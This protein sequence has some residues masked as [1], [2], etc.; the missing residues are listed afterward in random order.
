M[1]ESNSISLDWLEFSVRGVT[2]EDVYEVVNGGA[3]DDWIPL[4]SGG[5]GYH[6]Q[7]MSS[8][9][10][11][12]VFWD[13]RR[14]EIHVQVKGSSCRRM[15]YPAVLRLAVWCYRHKGH[16]SRL[17]LQATVP[18]EV[19]TVEQFREGLASGECVSHMTAG[20][21]MEEFTVG[22]REPRRGAKPPGNTVYLGSVKSRRQ[23]RVYDKGAESNGA[24][25]GTRIELQERDEAADEALRQLEESYGDIASVFVGRLVNAVDFRKVDGRQANRRDRAVWWAHVVGVVESLTAYGKVPPKTVEQAYAA[26]ERQYAPMVAVFVEAG[27]FGL[28]DLVD[29]GLKRLRAKHR[30][31]LGAVGSG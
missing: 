14:P 21:H 24:I 30:V 6:N 9:T 27:L 22:G 11:V 2:P 5:L 23:V 8:R 15:G 17:D 26:F 29:E 7:T 10:G 20:R 4:P 28:H 13:E 31:M 1:A 25:P 3:D 12:A 18:Y 19:L 16:V